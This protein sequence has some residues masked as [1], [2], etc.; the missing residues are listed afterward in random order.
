[1]STS[2]TVSGK[3]ARGRGLDLELGDDGDGWLFFPSGESVSA[4]FGNSVLEKQPKNASAK[5]KNFYTDTR[6]TKETVATDEGHDTH[7][8]TP[9]PCPT[10]ECPPQM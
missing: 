4:F 3:T 7:R 8:C 2:R 1:M 5:G 10:G 9:I 6:E